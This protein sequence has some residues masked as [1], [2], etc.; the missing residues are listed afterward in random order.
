MPGP[1]EQDV[2]VGAFI[3]MLVDATSLAFS[4]GD[5]PGHPIMATNGSPTGDALQ[6][7]GCS[8]NQ[9]AGAVIVMSSCSSVNT[10]AGA[11]LAAEGPPAQRVVGGAQPAA[12]RV[13]V[14]GAS[15]VEGVEL[16]GESIEQEGQVVQGSTAMHASDPHCETAMA[17]VHEPITSLGEGGSVHHY[18]EDALQSVG[19]WPSHL[20]PAETVSKLGVLL[21][22]IR[23]LLADGSASIT[24]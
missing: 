24:P 12:G 17:V 8:A 5:S 13:Y 19:G 1:Q 23:A 22:R 21:S 3:R 7:Q 16:V 2:A 11:A 20:S 18:Y 9:D 14:Q 4:G 6:A 10:E 15:L